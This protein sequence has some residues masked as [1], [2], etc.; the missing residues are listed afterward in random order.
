V[1]TPPLATSGCLPGVTRGILLE[2]IHIPGISIRE[3]EF[4]PAELD[5]A[6]GVFITSTTRNVLPVLEVGNTRLKTSA[7]VIEK[8]Q[9]AFR[10]YQLDYINSHSKKTGALIT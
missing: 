8:L 2:E 1:S 4:T 3:Q 9:S 10:A 5:S 7:E 6:D